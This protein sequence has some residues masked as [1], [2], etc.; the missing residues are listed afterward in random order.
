MGGRTVGPGIGGFTLGGGFSWKT[1]QFGLTCDTVKQYNMVLPN[2]TLKTVTPADTDLFFALKGGLNRF[3]AVYS[4]EYYT[5]KQTK[6]WGGLAIY[7][8][9]AVDQILQAT[10]DFQVNNKDPKAQMITTLQGSPLGPTALVLYF[11]DGP[12]RPA[13]YDGFKGIP[14]L[15]DSSRSQSFI[16]FIKA[17][18]S[19]LVTN[20]RGAFATLSTSSLTPKF[21]AAIK[22]DIEAFTKLMPLH[23]GSGVSYDIEPF[24]DYGKYATDSAYP[25]ANSPLPVRLS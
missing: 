11:Y 25:H 21:L 2:G 17:F 5:H 13:V 23:S 8:G 7:T 20:V 4:I 1:N 12:E 14:A 15:I 6:V 18:P 9:K 3:G 22:A 10:A 24:T 19:Q 16:S